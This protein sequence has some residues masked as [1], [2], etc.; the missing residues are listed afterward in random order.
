[1]AQYAIIKQTTKSQAAQDYIA[2]NTA[3]FF[4]GN[5][6]SW[7][8]TP[9][10]S[11]SDTSPPTPTDT[12]YNEKQIWDGIIGIKNISSTEKSLAFP[13]VD[14]VSGNYYD[15]YRDD[16]DGSSVNGVSLTGEYT[17]TK[18]LSLAKSNNLVLVNDSGTYRLYRCIDNRSSTTGYPV[19]STSKPTFITT[20]IQTLVDGYKWKYLGSLSTPQVDDFLTTTHCPIPSILG[21]ATNSGQ[22]VSVLMTSRG[23]GYTSTPT[24]TVKGD[25]TGLVLGTPVIF[26]GGIAYIPVTTAGT[27]YTYVTIT[28]SGGGTPT[29]TA[30]AK[31]IIAPT[32]GFA[33]NLV[34][35]IDPNY[36]IFKTDNINTD[37]YF[38]TRGNAPTSYGTTNTSYVTDLTYRNVGLIEGATVTGDA[39]R[40]FQEY[41]YTPVTGTLSYGDLLTTATSGLANA[42]ATVVGL[43]QDT[44]TIIES[45]IINASTKVNNTTH[46]INYLSHALVTGDTVLYSNGGGTSIGGLTNGNTY[47]VIKVD[48]DNFKLATTLSNAQSG[49]AIAITTGV[50]ASHTFTQNAVKYYVSLLRTTEQLIEPTPLVTGNLLTKTDSSA[51]IYLGPYVVFNGSSTAV[52]STSTDKLT[53]PSHQLMTG[54]PVIYSNGGGTTIGSTGSVLVSG[55]TY[56][57][58]RITSDEIKLATSLPNAT[59]GISIDLTAVGSGTSHKLTYTGTDYFQDSAVTK[60]SGNIIFTEY[61]NAITRSTSKEKFRFVLEF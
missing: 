22:I 49:S 27:G 33:Y 35:E 30:T 1:M 54:D 19:A 51:T 7:A 56:Y 52:V 29:T 36:V 4:F 57:V 12:L 25:G 5:P 53:L 42:V 39:A 15:I 24:V 18:P 61:R 6:V 3:R 58:I 26:S 41:R 9:G 55:S 28:I 2:S 31:A 45:I 20:Q 37:Q 21:S 48:V 32:N 38:V 40:G 16:Y 10:G 43:R 23:A 47:Y 13:R 8:V 60:Y 14:W 11:Y 17:N 34:S 50:G 59:N 46:V 44:S